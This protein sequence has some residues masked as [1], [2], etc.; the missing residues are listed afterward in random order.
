MNRIP[1]GVLAALLTFIA[2]APAGAAAPRPLRNT[3]VRKAD[4]G[5]VAPAERRARAALER[6]LGDEGVVSTDRIT[7]AARLV[8]RT[9]GFLTRR[10]VAPAASVAL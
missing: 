5:P 6:S 3:D 2:A 10:A 1:L 9:D 8:A 4:G 7:G